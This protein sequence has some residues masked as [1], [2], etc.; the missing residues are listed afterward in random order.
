VEAAAVVGRAPDEAGRCREPERRGN[1]DPVL[2]VDRDAGLARDPL[3]VHNHL[4][5][6]GGSLGR[7]ARR[8]RE[9]ER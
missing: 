2:R 6:E 3:V 5:P 1:V 9:P 8:R 4:S 7:S